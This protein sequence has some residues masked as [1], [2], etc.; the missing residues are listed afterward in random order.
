M[1][2]P[3]CARCGDPIAQSVD[4]VHCLPCGIVLRRF[5]DVSELTKE[6]K[7]TGWPKNRHLNVIGSDR[8]Q[9]NTETRS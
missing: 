7:A 9:A 4:M 8:G 3:L 1:S 6:L 2:A 5:K